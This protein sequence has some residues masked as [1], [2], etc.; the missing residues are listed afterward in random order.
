MHLVRY[1]TAL[2]FERASGP[3]LV[4][5]EA[6]HNLM[7]GLVGILTV[8]SRFSATRKPEA[9]GLQLQRCDSARPSPKGRPH[10]APYAR[11]GV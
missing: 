6:E 8:D 11:R 5:R 4:T 7:L 10:Y 3:T 2:D 1:D 9:E